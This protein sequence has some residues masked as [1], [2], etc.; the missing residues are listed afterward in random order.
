MNVNGKMRAIEPVPGMEGWIKEDDG[1][2]T[3]KYSVFNM[4]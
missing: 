2:S 1:G 4:L 3:F